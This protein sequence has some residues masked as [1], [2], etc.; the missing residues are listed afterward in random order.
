[1]GQRVCQR[2]HSTAEQQAHRV[3]ANIHSFPGTS[4]NRALRQTICE[5]GLHDKILIGER[6]LYFL[7]LIT[8]CRLVLN[9][10]KSHLTSLA[11]NLLLAI[12]SSSHSEIFFFS[13]SFPLSCSPSPTL[14]LWQPKYTSALSLC[15]LGL[16]LKGKLCW[17]FIPEISSEP[18]ESTGSHMSTSKFFGMDG[19]RK[20]FREKRSLLQIYFKDKVNLV[21][22]KRV[23]TSFLRGLSRNSAMY[24]RISWY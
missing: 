21:S 16:I 1:M 13:H 11:K 6:N 8:W 22:A 23:K 2:G 9:F 3:W 5:K 15:P 7:S 17:R 10:G 4:Q 20:N 14:S 24:K 19:Q 18:G 12:V